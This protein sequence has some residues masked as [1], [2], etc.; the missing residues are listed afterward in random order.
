MKRYHRY[1]AS[2]VRSPRWRI[3]RLAAKRRDGWQCVECGGRGR[4]EVD[5]KKPVRSH[6]ELAYEISNLQT[7]CSSCHSKKTRIEIGLDPNHKDRAA[8]RELIRAIPPV[9]KEDIFNNA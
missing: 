9:T 1:S 7:L 8:W 2:V 5:H 6:P 4:L 3:V